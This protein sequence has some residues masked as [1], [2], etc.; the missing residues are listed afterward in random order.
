VADLAGHANHAVPQLAMKD[1]ST[2]YAGPQSDHA[3][4]I[5]VSPGADPF[6]S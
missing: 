5:G 2:T 1:E 4:T 3:D 6:F